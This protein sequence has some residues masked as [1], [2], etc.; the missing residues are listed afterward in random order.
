[1]AA[2]IR[3]GNQARRFPIAV[4]TIAALE[5]A[6]EL[7]LETASRANATSCA[8]WSRFSGFFS[9]QCSTRLASAGDTLDSRQRR[10]ILVDDRAHGFRR[11]LALKRP[12][13]REHFIQNGTECKQI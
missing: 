3:A 7:V 9:R 2:A 10:R 5:G 11:G 4:G 13:A 8:D 12:F 6:L 1:M